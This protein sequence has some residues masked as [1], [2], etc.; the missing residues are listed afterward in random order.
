MLGSC[1]SSSSAFWSPLQGLGAAWVTGEPP[2][3]EEGEY[4]VR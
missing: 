1:F 3:Q 4:E 2:G